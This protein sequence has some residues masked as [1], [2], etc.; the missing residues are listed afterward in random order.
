MV[1]NGVIQRKL[2][3]LDDQVLHLEQ[4]FRDISLD[5]FR[6]DWLRRSAAERNL[7]RFRSGC[8]QAITQDRREYP[9]FSIKGS[10]LAAL[11]YQD[12]QAALVRIDLDTG[13]TRD[14]VTPY[15]GFSRPVLTG[16]SLLMAGSSATQPNQNLMTEPSGYLI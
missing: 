10:S 9:Q 15:V 13:R 16:S 7:Y 6:T 4:A 1:I 8:Q 2:A 5:D 12:G 11:A 14:V 3:Q